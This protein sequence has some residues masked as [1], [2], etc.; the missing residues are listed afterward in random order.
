MDDSG[1][2]NAQDNQGVQ[3]AEQ[4]AGDDGV[5]ERVYPVPHLF[6][7]LVKLCTDEGSLETIR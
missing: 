7:E 2:S 6:H 5:E 4:D 1:P 3:D